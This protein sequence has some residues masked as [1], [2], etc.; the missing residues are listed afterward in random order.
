MQRLRTASIISGIYGIRHSTQNADLI[1]LID[2]IISLV[3]ICDQVHGFWYC[4]PR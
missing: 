2:S 3:V 4:Y 1:A